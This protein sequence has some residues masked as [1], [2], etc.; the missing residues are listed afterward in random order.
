MIPFAEGAIVAPDKI[1]ASFPLPDGS[2]GCICAD[3]ACAWVMEILRDTHRMNTAP[4]DR[5]LLDISLLTQETERE[6]FPSSPYIRVDLPADEIPQVS[7]CTMPS[8]NEI[9]V[10]LARNVMF[11]ALL[12]LLKKQEIFLF[13][14]GLT[15]DSNGKGCILCGPSGVGK[16]TAVAKA[17]TVWEIL[18]DDLM[19]LTFRNGK[20]FAQPG[21]TWSSYL[22]EKNR[23]VD[24]DVT[25]IVEVKNTLILSRLGEVGIKKL[26]PM[27]T[28]LMVSGSFIEMTTWMSG[29]LRSPDLTAELRK[30]AFDG[31]KLLTASTDCH[32]LTSELSTDLAPYLRAVE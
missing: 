19:Y 10:K 25:R 29:F 5:R 18:G 32:C 31:V 4:G 22:L 14:G 1:Y 21:P 26:S 28:G 30:A 3:A 9:R 20:C 23:P 27:Q 24:C 17:G 8:D 16:S 2:S 11:L 12:P 15:V 13:H 6:Y 7:L